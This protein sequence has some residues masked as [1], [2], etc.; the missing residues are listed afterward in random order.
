MAEKD[1]ERMAKQ[2]TLTE[3]DDDLALR[4]WDGD[5]SVKGDIL[6]AWGGRV[7]LAIRK[8]YPGLSEQDA[9]DVVCE[10]VVRF[11]EYREKYDPKRAKVGTLLY[12]IA[13]RV[14]AEHISGQLSW[15]KA[16][17]KEE[18]RVA[19]F[20]EEV[21]ASA[22]NE[23]PPEDTGP[24]QS[25]FQRALEECWKAISPL[26]RDILR[27]FGDAGSYPLEAATLG[28]ELGVK[29]KGGTPIPGVSIRGEKKR[30]WDNIE[31]CMKRK[32]HDISHLRPT[33][34]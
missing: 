15:Q 8:C 22:P 25:P 26:Q 3:T 31:L 23:D 20:F 4:L 27:A 6:K 5:D 11:W 9:E 7:L 33:H 2:P 32:N 13:T 28:K 17:L 18:C 10:A 1:A 21:L 29:Y 34:D 16:R 14:A 19:E 24:K 30:G 12:K